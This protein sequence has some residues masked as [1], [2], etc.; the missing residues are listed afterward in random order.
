MPVF[1]ILL[2]GSYLLGNLYVFVRGLQALGQISLSFKWLYGLSYWAGA[3]LLFAM[4]ALRNSKQIPF[5]VGQVLFHI[6]S[7]WLVFTLYMVIFL[8][9]ADLVK[10]FNGAFRYGFVISL[11]FI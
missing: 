5:A 1:F 4:L 9:A 7:G 8:A 3:L 10:V 2:L 6:G 11:L